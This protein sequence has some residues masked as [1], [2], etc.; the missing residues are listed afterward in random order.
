MRAW[1]QSIMSAAAPIPPR[2]RDQFLRDVAVELSRCPE[3]G[4]G[5]IGRVVNELQR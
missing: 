5:L 1:V 3:L 2:D 4:P